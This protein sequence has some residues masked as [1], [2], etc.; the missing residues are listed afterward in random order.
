MNLI[1]ERSLD[2]R[3]FQNLVILTFVTMMILLGMLNS[4]EFSSYIL[5]ELILVFL[6]ILFL[7]ILFTKKGLRVENGN[8][9]VCV[10]L[11]GLIL[12]KTLLKTS[13]FQEINLQKGK[14][15]T[16]YAYSYDIKEFHNWEPDLNHSVTSFTICMI[17]ENQ[18][19]KILMLTKPEKTKLAINFIVENTNLKY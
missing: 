10:F 3:Q 16:N 18:K 4:V 8:L 19:Q 2:F 11:F 14:L 15:S 7:G 17:N 5:I 1:L 13:E 9:F 6:N 12:K